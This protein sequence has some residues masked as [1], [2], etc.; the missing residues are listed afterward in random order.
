MNSSFGCDFNKCPDVC[1]SD[2]FWYFDHV[3]SNC[4]PYDLS[5]T[6]P[7]DFYVQSVAF[8]VSVIGATTGLGGG[9]ILIPFIFLTTTL[10]TETVVPIVSM[11]IFGA[12]VTQY[13]FNCKLGRIEEPNRP[14]INYNFLLAQSPMFS[15]F[16]Y[17]GALLNQ[18]TS[19]LILLIVVTVLS[20]V[21]GIKSIIIAIESYKNKNNTNV[22][23]PIP[24]LTINNSDIESQPP[25]QILKAPVI[26]FFQRRITGPLVIVLL[27]YVITGVFSNY[28][29]NYSFDDYRYWLFLM[30]HF[31][32]LVFL[33]SG[34]NF[35]LKKK[36]SDDP[37]YKW[38]YLKMIKMELVSGFVGAYSSFVGLGGGIIMIPYMIHEKI[39]QP[40]VS[41]SNSITYVYST[42][43]T[44][45]QYYFT[46]PVFL[47]KYGFSLMVS[48]GFGGWCGLI[49]FN[50]Y[51]I[52]AKRHHL[53]SIVLMCS[54]F[55]SI[56][57]LVLS[58]AFIN[59]N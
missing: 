47:Y 32:A 1:G 43:A 11:A 13:G 9:G 31:I 42:L 20:I 28:R 51:I 15:F 49:I 48:A 55:C 21:S 44:V 57:L 25:L 39:P 12:S 24:N 7:F 46:A 38:T 23:T 36:Q 22:N 54:I 26:A 30:G 33:M 40:I 5:F 56:F 41:G 3:T 19:K 18:Y 14:F 27:W 6:K 10:P 34:V 45:L 8:M 59:K 53:Q 37:D 4:I 16:A 50:K 52:D 58:L 35:Y 2:D 17:F 29:K